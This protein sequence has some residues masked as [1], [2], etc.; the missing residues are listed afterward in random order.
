MF[1]PGHRTT[2][3]FVAGLSFTLNAFTLIAYDLQQ[4]RTWAD[5]TETARK[6]LL[7]PLTAPF[8]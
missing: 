5:R 3:L 8:T 1:T 6:R 4:E 2:V 7:L